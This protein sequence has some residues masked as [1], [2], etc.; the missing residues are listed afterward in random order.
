M[1]HASTPYEHRMSDS[2]GL[3]PVQGL[4]L[5]SRT[6]YPT[7][8]SWRSPTGSSLRFLCGVGVYSSAMTTLPS[9]LGGGA[10][11][12]RVGGVCGGSAAIVVRGWLV[13]QPARRRASVRRAVPSPCG[14]SGSVA[15]AGERVNG[16]SHR[17]TRNHPA[18]SSARRSRALHEALGSRKDRETRHP[19]T[20]PP[21]RPRPPDGQLIT[22]ASIPWRR[23]SHT[24]ATRE[25]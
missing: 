17:H 12:G 25:T 3:A 6:Q 21:A 8:R 23:G 14:R 7:S 18:L 10:P 9:M 13:W 22:S 2:H 15:R 11:D 24:S 20:A 5:M 1:R 19:R 4:R 16:S